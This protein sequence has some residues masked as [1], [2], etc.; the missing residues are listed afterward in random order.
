[1]MMKEGLEEERHHKRTDLQR[2]MDLAEVS[3][4]GWWESN[5]RT[6]MYTFSDNICRILGI[7]GNQLSFEDTVKLVR[8]EY[9]ELFQSELFE[10]SN[11]KRK[12]YERVVPIMTPQGEIFIKGRLCYHFEDDEGAGSFGMLQV[13]KPQGTNF[14]DNTELSTHIR[15]FDKI[16]TMLAD[17]MNDKSEEQIINHILRSKLDVYDVDYAFLMEYPSEDIQ[18]EHVYEACREGF[19]SLD[20]LFAENTRKMHWVD[21]KLM[22]GEPVVL[23]DVKEM[24]REALE[25][26]RQLTAAHTKSAMLLPLVNDGHVWGLIG[27][28]AV[29]QYRDWT[30]NDYM[31]LL[32]AANIISICVNINRAR[33]KRD[34]DVRNLSDMI[35][36]MPIGFARVRV[37]KDENGRVTDYYLMQTNDAAWNI[38][39]LKRR[40]DGVLSSTVHSQDYQAESVAF[41]QQVIDNQQFVEHREQLPG[42]K[43]FQRLAY[44]SAAGEVVEFM[45]DVS[46]TVKAQT[47][48]RRSDKLFEDVFINVPIGEAIY[49]N[50]G[51]LKDINK[52]FMDIFGLG[53]IRDAR[54]LNVLDDECI[55]EEY[56]QTLEENDE[57]TFK[58]EYDFCNAK[59]IVTRRRDRATFN[60]KLFKLFN[61]NKDEQIGY[62]LIVIENTDKI[63]A[64]NKA[65]DFENYFSLIS[66]YAQVGYV[67]KNIMNGT[68]FAV[69]Q[70]YKNMGE[71]PDTK[72]SN[73]IGVYSKMHPDDRRKMIEFNRQVIA[74]K[75]KNFTG[76]MRIHHDGSDK[77]WNWIFINTVLNKY[78]PE[79]GIVEMIGVNYDITAFK[80]SEITL[81]AARDK[82]EKMDKL[83]STFLA[84]MSHEIR[85]PLNAI[86]GFSDLIVKGGNEEDIES[87]SSIIHENCDLLLQLINDILDLS[88]M[89][90]GM[91]EFK[92]TDVDINLLCR[93]TVKA[94]QLKAQD[95][96][97]I[98][99]GA[100][101][102]ECHLFTDRN[103]IAQVITNFF[104]NAIKFTSRGSITLSYAWQDDTDIRFSVTD[105]GTGIG[106]ENVGKVFHRFVKLDS[107]VQGTGL[108]LSICKSIVEQMGGTIGLDSELGKGST[109]WFVIP[110]ERK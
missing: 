32:L 24:P 70:W 63:M 26:Y 60:C 104:T 96:V 61:E 20:H 86:V 23:D 98:I 93:D 40:P 9:R 65:R 33:D 100:H 76:E 106:E 95:G 99:F 101:E 56:I 29:R 2:Y 64:M 87:F 19:P 1:M 78:A 75:A 50:E 52:A 21:S 44:L 88:K 6:R 13:V 22:A 18:K 59:N 77:E 25:D 53:S 5:I 27:V 57:V 94:M 92:Y 105:T 16:S 11:H 39:G 109:F 36:Y 67:K 3:Q 31:W 103:R 7:E 82:A 41:L 17:F 72:L 34:S 45:V 10:F 84:N 46:E 55:K 58:V 28:L 73:I 47:E 4:T 89:E 91:M 49:S 80:E 48:A 83:K 8:K 107:F 66:E 69:R 102:P 90:S 12:F 79:E 30:N 71:S 97:Q 35:K 62:M 68:G 15:H 43:Y 85:T 54:G 42:G 81:T 51:V 110:K 37:V 38:Y 74:G 108:G 14:V